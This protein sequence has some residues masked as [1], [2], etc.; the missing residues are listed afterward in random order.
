MSH[1]SVAAS[2]V[3]YQSPLELL[4]DTVASLR[5]ADLDIAL[6]IIDNHSPGNYGNALKTRLPGEKIIDAQANRGFGFGH[7]LA[8]TFLPAAD[9]LLILN[10]DVV[11]HD[12]ALETMVDYL[13]AN[14]NVVALTPRIEFPNGRLQALNKRDPSVLDLFLRRF[15]P[16]SMQRGAIAQRMAAFEM[17]DVGYDREM[18]V[19]FISGCFMLLRRDAFMETGGFDTRFFMYLEDA[20]L[21]RRLRKLGAVRYVPQATITHHWRRGSHASFRLF[22]V[23]LHSMWVYFN[24]WGWRWW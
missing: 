19:E 7:N 6:V 24:K 13:D 3:T 16:I 18:D 17:R 11:I 22:L 12:G 4:A 14:P 8:F 20:D 23:M 1:P 5:Q 10:P 9:Y 15:V 2:I 21:S